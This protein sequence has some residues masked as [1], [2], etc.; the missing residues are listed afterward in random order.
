MKLL[1]CAATEMELQPF[2]FGFSQ[3]D[4]GFAESKKTQINFC[5][6]GIGSVIT[7]TELA[8]YPGISLY[9]LILQV[10]IAG[11]FQ[12]HLPIGSVVEVVSER[13]ADLGVEMA[14]G[15][16]EDIFKSGLYPPDQWPFTNGHLINKNT[17]SSL[18][19]V[20]GITVNKVH[21]S[22]DSIHVIRQIYNPDIET[23]EGAGFFYVALKNQ[24]PFCQIRAISNK[25]EPRNRASWDISM[26]MEN[27]LREVTTLLK[28][29]PFL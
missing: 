20:A 3:S 17:Y 15:Q 14:E 11:S 7:A 1:I 12:D 5:C 23:M 4:I 28:S 18:P 10:G 8:M 19:K 24:I 27:L 9:D 22:Q 16:F 6:T 2:R 25:V 21:G 13:F 29:L 26:A